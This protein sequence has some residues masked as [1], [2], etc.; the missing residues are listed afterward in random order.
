MCSDLSQNDLSGSFPE[1]LA[2]LG[3]GHQL[4]D[5]MYVT[6]ASNLWYICLFNPSGPRYTEFSTALHKI[7]WGLPYCVQS[8]W[9]EYQYTDGMNQL[10]SGNFL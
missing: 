9:F 1:S 7:W 2:K 4:I 8:C 10:G 6:L 3:G 5:N